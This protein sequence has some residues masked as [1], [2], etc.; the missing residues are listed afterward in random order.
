VSKLL[1]VLEKFSDGSDS[2]GKTG[3]DKTLNVQLSK[4]PDTEL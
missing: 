2:G 3:V 4:I 1:K